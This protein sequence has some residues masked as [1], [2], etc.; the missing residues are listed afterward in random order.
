MTERYRNAHR[1]QYD[2]DCE[3]RTRRQGCVWTSLS[4]GIDAQSGG[5]RLAAPDTVLATVH[6]TE[7]TNPATPGWSLPDAALAMARMRI[8]FEVH[9]GR[10]W[11]AVIEARYAGL[12]VVLQGDSDVFSNSTCSGVFDGDHCIGVH[13]DNDHESRARIDDPV[14]AVARYSGMSILR[15]YA[16]KLNPHILFGVFSHAVPIMYPPAYWALVTGRTMTYDSRGAKLGEVSG[17]RTQTAERR[18]VGRRWLFR[19]LEGKYQGRYLPAT[20]TVAY[21]RIA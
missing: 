5:L 10:G 11:D 17:F 9:S 13:P 18:K 14:C 6:P 8:P 20:S 12:Y 19:I 7:E 3:P 2:P 15:Q 4:N 21:T 16:E 1:S